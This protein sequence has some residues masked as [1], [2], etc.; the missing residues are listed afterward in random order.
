MNKFIIGLFGP[1]GVGKDSVADALGWPKA[2][3]AAT[4]KT[5]LKPIL[6]QAGIDLNVRE[7]KERVRPLMVALGA[8]MRSIDPFH[9]IR[10]VTIPDSRRVVFCDVRYLNEIQSVWARG[11]I[12]FELTRPGF[13][14]ANEEERRSFGEVHDYLKRLGVSLPVIA[15]TTPKEAAEAILGYLRQHAM[16]ITV[17]LNP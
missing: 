14:A 10:R 11:G 8:T 9:W 13:A 16:N 15:N 7:Q 6:D 3:F 1:A 5:D 2:S 12:V 4:L 17:A